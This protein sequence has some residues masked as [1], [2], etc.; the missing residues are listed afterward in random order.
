MARVQQV[1]DALFDG[2]M[3]QAL[4]I[5]QLILGLE[6]VSLDEFQGQLSKLTSHY[7]SI[8]ARE[9]IDTAMDR[10]QVEIR[11]PKLAALAVGKLILI[12]HKKKKNTHERNDKQRKQVPDFL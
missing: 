2:N 12:K 3:R 8:L 10:I 4:E 11:D 6:R 9:S 5:G 1:Y 7:V